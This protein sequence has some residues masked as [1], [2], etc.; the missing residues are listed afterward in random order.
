VRKQE[1]V[2]GRDPRA[3][4]RVAAR[5]GLSHLKRTPGK[6]LR[7]VR[8]VLDLGGEL[9]VHERDVEAFE[10]VVAVQRPVRRDLV[11]ARPFGIGNELG[12]QPAAYRR[13]QV[14]ET[15]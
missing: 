7:A 6:E 4:E 2:P 14:V 11:G 3:V 10:V 9:S 5:A 15:E 13:Q 1:E 12:V 8:A